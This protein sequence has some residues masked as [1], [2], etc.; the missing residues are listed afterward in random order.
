MCLELDFLYLIK[1]Y[2]EIKKKKLVLK[3][4]VYIICVIRNLQFIPS[5]FSKVFSPIYHAAK[6]DCKSYLFIMCTISLK[7][8]LNKPYTYDYILKY[9][10]K[11]YC[12]YCIYVQLC[13]K[14]KVLFL[15]FFI[16]VVKAGIF[17]EKLTANT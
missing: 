17:L 3:D 8:S 13:Y 6:T 1:Q 14:W 2:D 9:L 7:H 15:V 11:C 10:L 5:A 12:I 16:V 4:I